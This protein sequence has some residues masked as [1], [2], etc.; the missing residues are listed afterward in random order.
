MS[1]GEIAEAMGVPIDTVMS[2]LTRGR[3]QLRERLRR[4]RDQEVHRGLRR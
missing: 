2:D 3:G 1:C 4:A